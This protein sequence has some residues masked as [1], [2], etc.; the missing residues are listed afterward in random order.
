[1]IT[2]VLEKNGSIVAEYYRKLVAPELILYKPKDTKVT[3]MVTKDDLH[4]LVMISWAGPVNEASGFMWISLEKH[5]MNNA[6]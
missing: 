3:C 2:M 1:M 6:Q 5:L 4:E